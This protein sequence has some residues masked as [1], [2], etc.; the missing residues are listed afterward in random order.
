M[1]FESQKTSFIPKQA[2]VKTAAPER[3]VG[4]ATVFATFL[5]LVAIVLYGGLFV[6]RSVLNK[7]IN[8]FAV[9]LD[10]ARG[11][12]ETSLITELQT[13]DARLSTG[14]TLLK[15][16]VAL[17]P[18]FALLEESTVQTLR[19]KNFAMRAES[20]GAYSINLRGEAD[21]YASIAL[22]SDIF[23]QNKY[24]TDHIFSNLTLNQDG[25]ISFDLNAKINSG[26][27]SYAQTIVQQ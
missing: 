7:D 14:D 22:Q 1:A 8:D 12:F 3:G 23:S 10:R 15:Q 16:H 4:G 26:L 18:V 24:I 27:L 25:R 20:G 11:A 6:Y 13:V 5:A 21:D 17:S 19:Y 2:I 9:S